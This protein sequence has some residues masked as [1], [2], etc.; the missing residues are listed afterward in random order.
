[1]FR[2]WEV[3]NPSVHW[4]VVK[5]Q[6]RLRAALV[7]LTFTNRFQVFFLD[8]VVYIECLKLQLLCWDNL[9]QIFNVHSKI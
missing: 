3:Y 5:Y 4:T 1:M 9:P 8:E 7:Q 2:V 6:D